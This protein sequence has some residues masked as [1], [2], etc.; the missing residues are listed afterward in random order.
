MNKEQKP[1]R[2]KS[3]LRRWL[4]IPVSLT[5]GEF[6]SA[7]AGG[8]SAAGKQVTVDKALQLSAVWSCVRLLSETIATL[9][10]GFYERT[11][12]GRQPAPAHPLYELLHNQPN[13]DMTAVEFWEM[14]M[15]S[16]L[17]WGN[18]YGEIDRT[19]KRITALTPLRPERMKVER[20]STGTPVYTYRDPGS[21]GTRQIHERD[22]MH[23]RAFST[24]GIIGLSPISYARQTLGMAMATDET[25]ARVFKN[26]M[27]PSG[28]LSME[29]ILRKEQR[30]D[31]R[32][33]LVAQFAGS[34]HTGKMMVLEA[35]M[36]F[37]PVTMNPE[38]A[39]MLQTRA[40]NIEEICRWFRVWPGLIGHNAQ[41]QTMW[42][43]GVEQM[44]IGF[45]TFSLRPWL[46]RI[47]QSI[48]KSLLIPGER[49]RYFA[50][51][52]IEGLLRADSAAR[53]A[54]YSTMT[55]NGVMTR[56][57]ARQKENMAP[58]PGGDQLTVQSNLLPLEQLGKTGDSDAAKSALRQWLEI[59]SE[60]AT[61]CSAKTPP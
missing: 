37:Q 15:A 13:A 50:E 20:S 4:G 39:Q 21:H 9:P 45:L 6:W 41:G 22:L 2:V 26:G 42:G 47:E 40:F 29:Q 38:D 5:E 52:S 55:Q 43:S 1:G 33:S 49:N 25:S 3:A 60:E 48:R 28:V 35:G 27:R 58:H 34:M 54:F 23:I 30:E 31:I 8:E 44:L 51:F 24:N 53:A 17:L 56:N 61:A 7:F 57:E 10:V 14:V 59:T 12:D 16:L 46:T 19:G 36:K 18:A 11:R 32:D